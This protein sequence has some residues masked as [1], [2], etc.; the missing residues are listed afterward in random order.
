MNFKEGDVVRSCGSRTG[1]AY[2]GVISNF[3]H[4]LNYGTYLR[5]IKLYLTYFTFKELKY[6]GDDDLL[7]YIN[8]L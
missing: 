5:T 7:T 3:C 4:I 1:I 6:I 8:I 2:I